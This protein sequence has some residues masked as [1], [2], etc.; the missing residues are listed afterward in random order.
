[1]GKIPFTHRLEQGKKHPCGRL[2]APKKSGRFFLPAAVFGGAQ[3][4]QPHRQ[5]K[6]A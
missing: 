6:A 4:R 5:Q 2:P 3:Y 1:M